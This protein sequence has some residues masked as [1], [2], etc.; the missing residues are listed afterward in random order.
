[1][2]EKPPI[3]FDADVLL[4]F[5]VDAHAL[6][7]LRVRFTGRGRWTVTVREEIVRLAG[8]QPPQPQAPR[9]LR[10]TDW[11]GAPDRIE[12][13]D[14]LQRVESIR[15]RLARDTDHPRQHLGEATC[16]VLAK[17]LDGLVATDD[18]GAK[19]LAKQEGVLFVTTPRILSAMIRDGDLSCDE[20]WEIYRTM[21]LRQRGMP[22][23][24]R[25]ELCTGR[26]VD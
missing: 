3:V 19:A 8:R 22:D 15:E 2:H 9:A 1:M 23:L 26:F 21:R 17:R 10:G 16:I 20:G 14:E 13:Q 18:S 25:D 11:L 6:H 5:A 7:L 4:S 24:G 12:D